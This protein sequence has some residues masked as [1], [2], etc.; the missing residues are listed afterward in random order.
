MEECGPVCRAAKLAASLFVVVGLMSGCGVSVPDLQEF[1]ESSGQGVLLVK[2]IVQSI[3]CELRNSVNYVIAE[4]IKNVKYNRVRTA[5]WL[6]DWGVQVGLILRVEENGAVS[7]NAVWT[8]LGVASPLFTLGF[9]GTLSSTATREDKLNYYYR[10]SEL[11]KFGVCPSSSIPRNSGS[12]LVRSDLKLREW[13]VAT[14]L[15]S[16]T[17]AITVPTNTATPLKQNAL[18]HEVKFQVVS[19]GNITPAWD[20]KNIDYN[21][22]GSFLSSGRTRVHS[23]IVTF[24]PAERNTDG[25]VGAAAS[26]FLASQINAGSRPNF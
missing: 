3:H 11:L 5:P 24:G 8:R 9:G 4:D 10:V 1:H 20:L 13:L 18:S 23:L 21:K 25:L 14:V 16:G 6:D 12:L 2:D 26:S 19:S 17:N 15:A 7:P 22:S